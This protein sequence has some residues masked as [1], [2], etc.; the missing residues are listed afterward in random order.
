MHAHDIEAKVNTLLRECVSELIE[1]GLEQEVPVPIVEICILRGLSINA[2]PSL[3]FQDKK[4]AGMLDAPKKAIYYEA[5]D[6]LGRQHFSIAHELGHWEL[7]WPTLKQA[8][9]KGQ[10]RQAEGQF[11]DYE[12]MFARYFR[13]DKNFASGSG[14]LFRDENNKRI[15]SNPQLE[16]DAN[17]FAQY[18]MMPE[19]W[20][21]QRAEHLFGLTYSTAKHIL[22]HQFEV[23]DMAMDIRLKQL[24]LYDKFEYHHERGFFTGLSLEQRPHD[25]QGTQINIAPQQRLRNLIAEYDH[26][27]VSG[28]FNGCISFHNYDGADLNLFDIN[29]AV[30]IALFAQH[31]TYCSNIDTLEFKLPDQYEH[32]IRHTERMGLNKY[33]G[34][35][36]YSAQSVLDI[37]SVVSGKH[38]LMRVTD[39]NA[40][41]D[42][43]QISQQIARKLTDM[44]GRYDADQEIELICDA[45]DKLS[46]D[47]IKNGDVNLGYGQ[48]FMGC[49]LQSITDKAEVIGYRVIFSLGTIGLN[50]ADQH[51]IH[52]DIDCES[53][54]DALEMYCYEDLD[55]AELFNQIANTNGYIQINTGDVSYHIGRGS[56]NFFTGL[57]SVPGIQITAMVQINIV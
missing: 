47:I 26:V 1:E 57:V 8:H 21:R 17:Y 4:L 5:R 28:E 48:G 16:A 52:F 27:R 12:D 51:R 53:N 56:K 36:H 37:P 44:L 23:S 2:S 24:G 40:N 49:E 31:A 20:I 54:Y 33:L 55:R 34:I 41:T 15:H 10:Y 25:K 32:L 42:I 9:V 13:D 18:L 46:H 14:L 38:I 43:H 11:V 19:D 35:E 22:A 3:K 39:F 30:E 50:L 45:C 6:I 29:R 7:H